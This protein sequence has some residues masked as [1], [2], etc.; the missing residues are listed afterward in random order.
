MKRL[1]TALMLLASSAQAEHKD[2]ALFV[3]P[4]LFDSGLMRFLLPRFSLKTGV[5]VHVELMNDTNN[6]PADAIR[7]HA[8]SGIAVLSG[9]GQTF[10]LSGATSDTP[11]S[12]KFTDWLLS[13]VGQRTIGQFARDGSPVFEGAAGSKTV[14]RLA[15]LT[16]D[17]KRGEALA[18][19]NCG[20]CHVIGQKNRMKGIGSTPSFPLL[21]SFQN[22]Q[23]RFS[24]FYALNPHPSFS[25][26]S[27][28]TDPFDKTRP[29]PISPL[30]LTQQELDDIVAFAGSVKPAGLGKPLDHQ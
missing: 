1:I 12:R 30:L 2:L 4:D 14:G 18:Y 15:T 9:M 16:G 24:A 27:G 21:R 29:P 11:A 3:S 23:D 6:I 8:D 20:R 25:Q 17:A 5:K 13:D 28:I 26:V 7:L 19:S 22:W 10:A